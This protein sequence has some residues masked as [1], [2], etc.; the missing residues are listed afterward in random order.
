MKATLVRICAVLVLS[1]GLVAVPAPAQAAPP[2]VWQITEVVMQAYT[3]PTGYATFQP[4]CPAGQVPISGGYT[5]ADADVRRV[6]EKFEYSSG[7]RYIVDLFGPVGS[8]ITA[9][10]LCVPSTYFSGVHQVVG[11]FT[12]GADHI[13]AGTVG[14]PSG[15]KALHAS[16][17]F[18]GV[19][20]T[21]LTTYPN[22]GLGSWYVKGWNQA[23]GS[24][25]VVWV[26]CA[27]GAGFEWM[28]TVNTATAIGWGTTTLAACGTG[29]RPIAGGTYHS[30]GDGGAITV[31][32]R[33]V[34]TTGSSGSASWPEGRWQSI[35]LS[36][37]GGYM[38][39]NVMCVPS[40][41]PVIRL[42]SAGPTPAP[43]STTAR[44]AFTAVDPPG[45]YGMVVYCYFSAPGQP[46]VLHQPCASP[47]DAPGLAD[48]SYNLTVHADTVDGRW[49]SLGLSSVIIDTT[50]PVVGL[51]NALFATSSP[52]LGLSVFD[53]TMVEQLS[54]SLDGTAIDPCGDGY[55]PGEC[56]P[57]FGCFPDYYDYRYS[58]VLPLSGLA[59]GPHVLHVE[60]VDERGNSTTGDL[61][62]VV[63]TVKPTVTQTAPASPFTVGTSIVV[64]WKG[65]DSGSGV[66]SYDIRWQKAAHTADAF[67]VWTTVTSPKTATSRTI[68]PVTRGATYCSTVRASDRAGNLS[69][70]TPARCTAIPLDDR[71]LADSSGWTRSSPSG[72]FRGTALT[73]T[74][75]GATL[76][77]TGVT[78]KRVAVVAKK[79]PTCGIV[80]VYVSGQLVG[81]VDLRAS[82]TSRQ[83]V[84][85]PAF[86]L[87]TGTVKLKVLTSGKPVQIDALGVSRR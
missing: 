83:V 26:Q 65:Q 49:Q 24:S 18:G 14:C 71:D 56:D 8:Q 37:S 10:V 69:T 85:L 39:T 6:A 33:P 32:S 63:D 5:A 16:V 23:I 47:F 29:M 27:S 79:C 70:V 54:C 58:Q 75:L 2:P 74:R 68:S 61:P 43:D 76:A 30:G 57:E 3:G 11:A 4:A 12:V 36:T 7:G 46:P 20:S 13:A 53:A 25:M 72:W 78:L 51:Q 81:K 73:S 38:I 21:V 59:H 64:K 1:V 31:Q 48:G 67:G 66:E 86:S 82:T 45:G 44:W 52:S 84:A 34:A 87:R 17:T 41:E 60:A 9:R 62:F 40:T 55:H 42:V 22:A 80:G 15:E 28:R 50:V 35:S 77:V 19:E